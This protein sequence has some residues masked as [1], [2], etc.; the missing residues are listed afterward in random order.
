MICHFPGI[1]E[2][3][4]YT[5]KADK[6]ASNTNAIKQWSR[7]AN[8]G[9]HL[10]VN[11]AELL[12]LVDAVQRR[13]AAAS[14]AEELQLGAGG[15]GGQAAAGQALQA[16]R[17]HLDGVQTESVA[18]RWIHAQ[19]LLLRF[20][21]NAHWRVCCRAAPP[22]GRCCCYTATRRPWR[23]ERTSLRELAPAG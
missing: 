7:D 23:I 18:K 16:R 21:F 9:V 11:V 8:A 13:E 17:G 10:R 19:L 3:N 4:F 14:E 5:A 1:T 22:G 15:H 6:R 20:V 2:R 12:Q